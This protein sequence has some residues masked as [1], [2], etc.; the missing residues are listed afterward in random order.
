VN[1]FTKTCVFSLF[2]CLFIHGCF[3]E[4]WKQPEPTADKNEKPL[5]PNLDIKK[6]NEISDRLT[7]QIGGQIP[8]AMNTQAALDKL[9]YLR[10]D[11]IDPKLYR[12][13]SGQSSGKQYGFSIGKANE[14]NYYAAGTAIAT[15]IADGAYIHYDLYDSNEDKLLISRVTIKKPG[16]EEKWHSYSI[17]PVTGH[18]WLAKLD[19]GLPEIEVRLQHFDLHGALVEEISFPSISGVGVIKNFV[20]NGNNAVLYEGSR[21]WYLNLKNNLQTLI[22]GKYGADVEEVHLSETWIV[23]STSSQLIGFDLILEK[24]F[25]LASQI[26]NIS[27]PIVMEGDTH[28]YFQ[29]GIFLQQDTLFYVGHSGVFSYFLSD[30]TISVLLLEPIVDENHPLRLEYR[31]PQVTSNGILFVTQLESASSS[32]GAE[33]P[34]VW[35]KLGS[36]DGAD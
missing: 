12:I 16:T 34:V 14:W 26:K 17:D 6:H 3:A 4:I 5:D 28:H 1:L 19:Y 36:P 18:L 9:F 27:L 25:D 20:I 7:K 8:D 33:G 10:F 21:L 13:D 31:Y 11:G 22:N 32:V 30:K 35:V 24:D 23:F 2:F 29:E 15:A